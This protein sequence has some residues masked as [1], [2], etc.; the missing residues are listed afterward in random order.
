MII[1][2]VQLSDFGIYSGSETFNLT[3][4]PLNGFNR[5]IVLFSGKN[6]AGKT[7]IIEAIRLCLHGP[8][9]LGSRVSR[10]A[11]ESYLAKYVHVPLNSD[12]RPTSAKIGLDLDHVS[13][14]RKRAFR[15]ERSW[16]L[17]NSGVKQEL[18]IWEDGEE[19]AG[20]DTLQQK[21]SFLRELMPPR[22][23]DLLFFDGEKLQLLAEESTSNS[24]MADTVRA[25]FGLDLVEQLQR[26]LDIY[27]SR[28]M[29]S[30][31]AD[32]LKT[33]LQEL[34]QKMTDL[35]NER[36]A[37]R[38]EQQANRES[39]A[40]IGR[41]IANQEQQIASE[42]KWF[43]ERLVSLR[44]DRQRLE[45]EI[46]MQRRQAQE[47]TGGLIPFSIV[48]QMCQQVAK[49]LRL[50][51]E[52]QLD[53][54]SQEVLKKQIELTSAE[55]TSPQFW[56]D[57]GLTMDGPTQQKMLTR[58]EATLRQAIP[59]S[60]VSP[61]EVIL[62]VSGRD[63]Q[64][65]LG[66]IDQALADVPQQ[67]CQVIH[68]LNALEADLERIDHELALVPADEALNPLVETLHGYN[69]ELG[70]SQKTA[71]DLA[72]RMR[73]L[74]YEIEQTHYELRR[75]RQQIAEREH[76]NRSI[77]LAARTQL[78]LE[79]YMHE[80]TREKIRLLEKALMARFNELCR[81]ESLVDTVKVDPETFEI[82][83][84]RQ[85]QPFDRN[86]LSAGE[87]QLL[88]IATMWA[89]REV[90]GIP[91]P[92]IIDT[93]LG[94]LDSDHRLKMVQS[95]FPRASHQVVLLTMDTELDHQMLSMLAPAITRTYHLNYDPSQGKTD[96]Q[97][98]EPAS[99]SL[100]EEVIA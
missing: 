65:L 94:R 42:G 92:V 29:A 18:R 11:Y 30:R 43:A 28:K 7:T 91:M 61:D 99:S 38:V 88:A 51:K 73:R 24:L 57:I 70:R 23:A 26:D 16:R 47:L 69:Q 10:A 25:L 84:H 1:R 15:I 41:A 35:K 64:K 53:R 75:V 87:K 22:V 40:E 45:I 98:S 48:P 77:Q 6:G 50:E 32:S 96:V 37:L 97:E 33:Q 4:V 74:E 8:L 20:L 36:A 85:R 21:E 3:P 17:V 63:R 27:L 89:M 83:L 78:V 9:A 90:S 79:E 80:L 52:Y 44:T 56:A 55:I 59:S 12:N 95:Y 13:A 39:M 31:N 62:E 54:A 67:F 68:R 49:R 5:P 93:P 14:G 71:E 76:D 86:Q 46:E 82:T 19:L 100:Q 60:D 2:R 72:E 66:W 34:A 58:I 81:K